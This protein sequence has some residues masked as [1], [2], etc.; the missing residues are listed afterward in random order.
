[1]NDQTQTLLMQSLIIN[2][3][4]AKLSYERVT[5]DTCHRPVWFWFGF[6]NLTNT[7]TAQS[8][9]GFPAKVTHP[10]SQRSVRQLRKGEQPKYRNTEQSQKQSGFK[11][12]WC[13]C[14]QV[15]KCSNV[16]AVGQATLRQTNR[17]KFQ[18]LFR[19]SVLPLHMLVVGVFFVVGFCLFGFGF[20]V[21]LFFPQSG[22]I[23]P[24]A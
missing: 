10:T 18:H 20:S 3:F 2:I 13:S 5:Q 9:Q 11:S 17:V 23:R 19:S 21:F 16:S 1:M 8:S 12:A 14:C 24:H 22:S 6:R 7:L 4:W 15:C